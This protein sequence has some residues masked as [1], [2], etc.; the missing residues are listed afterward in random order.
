MIERD[1]NQMKLTRSL[2]SLYGLSLLCFAAAA[3][4]MKERREPLAG[5]IVG[6]VASLVALAAA[7]RDPRPHAS[8]TFLRVLAGVLVVGFLVFAMIGR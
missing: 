1:Q 7:A 5:E 4:L 6:L 3:V 8:R 2:P